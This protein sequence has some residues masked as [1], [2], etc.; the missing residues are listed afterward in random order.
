MTQCMPHL[1]SPVNTTSSSAEM[2]EE[3]AALLEGQQHQLG[4]MDIAGQLL[5]VGVSNWVVK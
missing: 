1:A 4:D 5:A 3:E 2:E